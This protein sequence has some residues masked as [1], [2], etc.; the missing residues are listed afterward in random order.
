VQ[1]DT[2]PA[3]QAFRDLP[4]EWQEARYVSLQAM[5][6][7]PALSER[8]E[9]YEQGAGPGLASLGIDFDDIS[10]LAFS[11]QRATVCGGEFDAS[12]IGETLAGEGYEEDT[13]LGAIIWQHPEDGNAVAA[14]GTTRVALAQGV[15]EVKMCVSVMT[16]WGR[17]L[18][19]DDDLKDTVSR[20]PSGALRI[21][22]SHRIYSGPLATCTS[23]LFTE[24]GNLAVQTLVKYLDDAAASKGLTDAEDSFVGWSQSWGMNDAETV[25]IRHFVRS[26]GTASIGNVDMP[27]GHW[28]PWLQ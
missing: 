1:P 14:L 23:V 19:D 17:S 7:V 12:A 26:T 21:D 8:Y 3:V 2:T 6:Q 16:G 25:Q 18:M 22:A 24:S 5:R 4:L 10:W 13:Y 9:D 28:A 20:L 15:D 11:A 27:L